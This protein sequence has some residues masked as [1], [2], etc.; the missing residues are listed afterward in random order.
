MFLYEELDINELIVKSRS[1]D[2]AAFAEIL[3]RYSP[4]LSKLISSFE[5]NRNV[6]SEAFSEASLALHKATLSYRLDS[7]EVTFG[8]FARICVQHRLVDFFNAVSKNTEALAMSVENIEDMRAV[9][10]AE[11]ILLSREKLQQCFSLA[12]EILS[13]YEY[14]VFMLYVQNYDT[15][16]ICRELS[17]DRKSVENAK[18]R[19]LKRLRENSSLFAQF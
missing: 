12:R 13:D 14:R 15:D 10:S 6:W 1:G 2:D 19:M 18:V 8:L 16:A 9:G 5:G 11:H 17:R 3:N 7:S 4:M